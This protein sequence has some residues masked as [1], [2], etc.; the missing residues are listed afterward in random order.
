[1]FNPLTPKLP[2]DPL[3]GYLSAWPHRSIVASKHSSL[4]QPTSASEELMVVRSGV[5]AEIRMAGG[6]REILALRFP[7]ETILPKPGGVSHVLALV[8][9][10]VIMMALSDMP[11]SASDFL[12]HF[13]L[14]MAQR[15]ASILDEWMIVRGIRDAVSRVAHLLC[16]FAY[17]RE[18]AV[19]EAGFQWPLTQPQIAD[20]TGQTA[21]NVNRCLAD[22]EDAGMI[23]RGRPIVLRDFRGLAEKAQFDPGYLR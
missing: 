2:T 22:L 9:S 13:L 3:T 15:E 10:V 16:E 1:M 7:G 21:V 5:V 4:R 8:S 18:Q 19:P 20:I 11:D 17:R 12:D 6:V 14:R 23:L